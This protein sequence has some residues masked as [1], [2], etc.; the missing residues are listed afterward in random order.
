MMSTNMDSDGDLRQIIIDAQL[1]ALPQ[2]AVQLLDLAGDPSNGPEE[3]AVPIIADPGLAGQVLRFV[4]SSYF[5]FSQEIATIP[6]AISLVGIHTIK[7][8]ALWSAVFSLMPDPAIEMF[9]LKGLWQDSLRRALFAKRLAKLVGAADPEVV[10]SAALLQDVA[11][12]LVVKARANMYRVL[13]EQ[14]A[15]TGRR[16]SDLEQALLGTNHAELGGLVARFWN[17]PND[18]T[19][20]IQGHLD[21]VFAAGE[22]DKHPGPAAVALSALLPSGMDAEWREYDAFIKYY[23]QITADVK[24]ELRQVLEDTDQ[25]FIDFAPVLQISPSIRTLVESLDMAEEAAVES[26]PA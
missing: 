18:F 9:D 12:P 2:A 7:N 20:L 10:F 25:A 22:A 13:L 3:L 16:L 21:I 26:E 11:I 4:N 14:R 23:A 5:G 19:M 17:L 1:P 6:R 15:N 8:F 24:S